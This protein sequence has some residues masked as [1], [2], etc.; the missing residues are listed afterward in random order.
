MQLIGQSIIVT[1]VTVLSEIQ[2]V[3]KLLCYV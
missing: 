2:I 1:I 3:E